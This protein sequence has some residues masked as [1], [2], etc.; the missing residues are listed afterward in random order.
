MLSSWSGAVAGALSLACALASG[1]ALAAPGDLDPDF[2]GFGFAGKITSTGF[3]VNAVAIDAQGRLVLAG[4]LGGA[5]HVQRRSGPRFLTVESASTIIDGSQQ[6]ATAR[7]V[8]IAPDGKIVLA[9]TVVQA[10]GDHDF[11]VARFH[12]NLTLDASFAGDGTQNSDFDDKADDA[13]AVAV[14][15]DLRIVVAGSA[16]IEGLIYTDPDWAVARFNENGTLDNGFSG[17]GKWTFDSEATTNQA[18]AVAVQG[19][20]KILVAGDVF[21][22][23]LGGNHDL[24]VVRLHPNGAWDDDFGD[25][26]RRDIGFGEDERALAIALDPFNGSIAIAGGSYYDDEQILLARVLANGDFDNF[27]NANG[28]LEATIDGKATAYAV[29]IQPDHKMVVAGR[30]FFVD[31]S[32]QF[33]VMRFNEN[34]TPDSTFGTGGKVFTPF[35]GNTGALGLAMQPDGYLIAAGNQQVARYRPEGSLDSGGVTTLV[36]DPAHTGS[37]ATALA[38]GADAKLVAAGKSFLGDYDMNLARY[39]PDYGDGLDTTFGTDFPKTGLSYY[40]IASSLEIRTMAVRTDGKT[41]VGGQSYFNS[42]DFLIAR[43]NADGTPD[44]ACSGIGLRTLDF[45]AGDDSVAAMVVIGDRIYAAGTINGPTNG[46]FGLVRLDNACAV[47]D[48]G[49]AVANEYKFQFDLGGNEVLGGMVFHSA[50]GIV[51]AG[52]SAGNVVLVRTQQNP[53]TGN[54]TLNTGFGVGGKAI[55]DLGSGEVVTGLGRQADGK[56]VVSGTVGVGGGSN[57]FVARLTTAGQLDEDFGVGGIAYASFNSIDNAQALA[58]RSDDAIAVAGC[59][60]TAAGQVFAVAQFTSTGALD[61]GFS[62]DGRATVRTGPSG[63]ECALAATFVGP[64]RLAIGGYSSVFGV[65]NFVLA[66]FQSAEAATT[67]TTTTLPSAECGDANG[68]GS[69]T[70]SDAL[71]ALKTAVGTGTCEVCVCDTDASGS[72]AASDALRVLRAAVGQVVT[73]DCSAC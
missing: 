32:D 62:D 36:F 16:V 4:T 53:N 6:S 51:L 65:R 21:T 20:G 7:A 41:V 29:L 69:I 9:G 70:A 63:E 54:V 28:R 55:L 47:D 27:F 60:T 11:A 44:G 38:V 34:G 25:S 24:S 49:G 17:N 8:A 50:G 61:Q 10:G 52:T 14:Q 19:D 45:T 13:Y 26:G 42:Y 15:D 58:I 71:S 2:G 66:A 40:G 12:D 30:A 48:A 22:G 43:F 67:T 23:N 59:T 5:F 56:L 33:V 57:Y 64:E 73:L 68:D 18:R 3:Q 46:N 1:A 72:V 35:P 39:A 31:D 37:E